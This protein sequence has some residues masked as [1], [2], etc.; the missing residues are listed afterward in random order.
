MNDTDNNWWTVEYYSCSEDTRR[1][2]DG[3]ELRSEEKKKTIDEGDPRSE[4]PRER[5]TGLL[6]GHPG[7]WTSGTC[8]DLYRVAGSTRTFL[9]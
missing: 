5:G 2:G 8:N 9:A 4:G 1:R 3:E 7:K 6:T